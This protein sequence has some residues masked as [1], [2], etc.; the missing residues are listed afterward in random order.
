MVI[1]VRFFNDFSYKAGAK[2]LMMQVALL[3][4]LI[5]LMH[6]FIVIKWFY[7]EATG[8]IPHSKKEENYVQSV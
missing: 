2:P 3:T 8:I 1:W 4:N 6:Y 7:H 5:R